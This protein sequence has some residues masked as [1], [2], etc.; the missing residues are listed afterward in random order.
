MA[1]TSVIFDIRLEKMGCFLRARALLGVAKFFVNWFYGT[2]V[3]IKINTVDSVN[4]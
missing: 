3:D 1:T 2:V 4:I